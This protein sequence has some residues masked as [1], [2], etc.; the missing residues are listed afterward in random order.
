MRQAT[1]GDDRGLRLG[2]ACLPQELLEFS[3]VGQLAMGEL[4][5][6]RLDP[7]VVVRRER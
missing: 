3:D 5:F 4:E 1:V 2:E 6:D 7:G